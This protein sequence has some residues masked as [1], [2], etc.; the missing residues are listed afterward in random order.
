MI[1]DTKI[2]IIVSTEIEGWQKLNVAARFSAAE[3]VS[4]HPE[5]L[6]APYQDA[7]GTLYHSLIGEPILV[8]GATGPGTGARPRPCAEP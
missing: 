1:F 8:Y 2:A 4:G 6:G 7:S 3:F 5:S